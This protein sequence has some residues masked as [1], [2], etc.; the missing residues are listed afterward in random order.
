VAD[1]TGHG[2]ISTG[3]RKCLNFVWIA[4]QWN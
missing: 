1:N 2:L 4:V 3:Y